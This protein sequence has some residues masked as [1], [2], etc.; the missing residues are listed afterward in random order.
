MARQWA[1]AQCSTQDI[2]KLYFVF[3]ARQWARHSV[4][5]IKDILMARQWFFW[6]IVAHMLYTNGSTV[7]SSPM[8]HI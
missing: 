4:V 7:A 5:D 1:L 8:Q 3:M 2:V 6:P